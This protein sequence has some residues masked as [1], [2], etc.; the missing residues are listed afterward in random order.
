M[1]SFDLRI[2][3]GVAFLS[4]V[5][6]L[7]LFPRRSPAKSASPRFSRG[8]ESA[9]A[10]VIEIE[11]P[12]AGFGTTP[13]ANGA[14]RRFYYKY[15]L[16]V[17]TTSPGELLFRAVSKKVGYPLSNDIFAVQLGAQTRIRKATEQEWNSSHDAPSLHLPVFS[18]TGISPPTDRL[19]YA[20]KEFISSGPA[21]R[22][23]VKSPDGN[24]LAILSETT[25]DQD[26]SPRGRVIPF[27]TGDGSRPREG[28]FFLD[29]YNVGSG[30]RVA[31]GASH[32]TLQDVARLDI[33]ESLWVDNRYF[34]ASLDFRLNTCFIATVSR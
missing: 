19:P 25:V 7:C 33:F 21:I 22:S 13:D 31:S 34:I 32:Y 10:K 26:Q 14:V 29:I 30:E 23:A 4:I 9:S 11:F 5:A 24:W 6:A 27:V 3:G 15:R 16:R 28:D 20:G 2:V 17:S 1:R 8:V 18:F 12:G